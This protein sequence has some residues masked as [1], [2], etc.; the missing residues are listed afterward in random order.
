LLTDPTPTRQWKVGVLDEMLG[1]M[2]V[3]V[4]DYQQ[5]NGSLNCFALKHGTISDQSHSSQLTK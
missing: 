2:S 5:W 3:C 1:L 4:F